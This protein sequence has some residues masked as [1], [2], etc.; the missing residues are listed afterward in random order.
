MSSYLTIK[1]GDAKPD[2]LRK[3]DPATMPAAR[4]QMAVDSFA[5]V[6][7]ATAKKMPSLIFVFSEEKE[8]RDL[9]VRA[10]FNPDKAPAPGKEELTAG[11]KRSLAVYE[12]VFDNVQDV[13]LR[14]LLRFF[15]CTRM[16][17]TKVPGSLHP[18]ISEPMAPL[19]LV[20]DAQGKVATA[21]SQTRIDS[22]ALTM[23]LVDVLKKGGLRDVEPLCASTIKLMDEME[24]ALVVKGK[25]EVKMAELKATLAEYEAKDRK[26][27]NKTGTPLPPSSATLRAKQAVS[28]LQP[29]LDSAEQAYVALKEKDA[30]ML[31]T[32]GVDLTAWQRA[33]APTASVATATATATASL[34]TPVAGAAGGAVPTLRT[35]TSI[36][37]KTLQG[38]FEQ[39]EN[40]IVVLATPSGD[41]VQIPLSK[42]SSSDQLFAQQ[43]ANASSP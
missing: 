11:A 40:G 37:G 12:R 26:R 21:L 39:F 41:R 18:D 23:G 4:L 29:S 30:A 34:A 38:R 32:A 6:K 28:A 13:P 35:W 15:Q 25:I 22:R 33:V 1:W 36:S 5:C 24:N 43:L 31:R 16:D 9:G 10:M 20:V 19:V 2:A 7:D 8:K 14:V 17:V 27:P 3:P 42:L